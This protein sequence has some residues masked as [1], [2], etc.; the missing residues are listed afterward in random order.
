[1]KNKTLRIVF[2]LSILI[3][4]AV[5]IWRFFIHRETEMN[6]FF[7]NNPGNP[8]WANQISDFRN[9]YTED[10]VFSYSYVILFKNYVVFGGLHQLGLEYLMG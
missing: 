4:A 8:I 9:N 3:F 1:M 5:I 7:E 2:F 6:E 10:M